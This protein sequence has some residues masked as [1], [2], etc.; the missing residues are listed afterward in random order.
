METNREQPVRQKKDRAH[1]EREIAG[2]RGELGVVVHEIE[3]RTR[4]AVSVRHGLGT[5]PFITVGVAALLG[6]ALALAI[7]YPIHRRRRQAQRSRIRNLRFALAHLMAHPEDVVERRRAGAKEKLLSAG[8]SVG[9][10]GAK[11]L[12]R[13]WI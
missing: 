9:T 3:R 12:L 2:L 7:A 1:L 5:H 4:Q 11:R 8:T 6:G 13:R 10:F